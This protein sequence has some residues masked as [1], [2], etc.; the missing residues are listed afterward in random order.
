M[1]AWMLLL[2]VAVAFPG[3][4][5]LGPASVYRA[6]TP[7]SLAGYR[8]RQISEGVWEVIYKTD[9]TDRDGYAERYARYRAAE[10]A[11]DAGYTFIQIVGTEVSRSGGLSSTTTTVQLTVHG[12]RARPPQRICEI[13]MTALANPLSGPCATFSTEDA[14]R[15]FEP[16]K[17]HEGPTAGGSGPA[18]E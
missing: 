12:A 3:C 17:R 8:D 11:R 10:L 6:Y 15:Q 1:R 4:S 7:L 18:S 9:S 13:R 2:V 14:L 16:L 5:Q